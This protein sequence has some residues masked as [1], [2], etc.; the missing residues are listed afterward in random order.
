MPWSSRADLE[1]FSLPVVPSN[2]FDEDREKYDYARSI[3]KKA[4][5]GLD[6][7]R[8]SR[9]VIALRL[10]SLYYAV[11]KVI[12]PNELRTVTYID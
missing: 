6:W 2:I 5:R 4:H 7:F 9:G 11:G 3:S 1:R 10:V 8:P 12:T